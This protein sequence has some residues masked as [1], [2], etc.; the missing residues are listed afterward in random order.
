M[1]RIFLDEIIRN[2]GEISKYS[3][4]AGIS[5]VIDRRNH[6]VERYQLPHSFIYV[7]IIH[8]H[9]FCCSSESFGSW[10]YCCVVLAS[11]IHAL[12][13]GIDM[14]Q[15]RPLYH[16]KETIDT[17]MERCHRSHCAIQLKLIPRKQTNI[18]KGLSHWLTHSARRHWNWFVSQFTF[19]I[20]RGISHRTIRITAILWISLNQWQI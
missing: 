4:L 12:I 15:I 9:L 5:H 2:L 19:L 14:R 13:N 16:L 1:F 18:S 3:E 17:G 10:F 11:V 8:G 6:I 7:I 20:E